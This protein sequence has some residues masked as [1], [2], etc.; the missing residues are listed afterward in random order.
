MGANAQTSVP[1]FTAGEVLTAAN[2][3]ISARTGVP[4][5]ATTGTRD[6]AFGG[7]GEKTLA[8][9]QMCYV[10]GTG[11]QSYN[12]TA[13]VTWGTS[14]TPAGVAKIT[15]QTFSAVSSVSV[16]N[17]FSSTYVNYRILARFTNSNSGPQGLFLRLRASSTDATT[18]Y[19]TLGF[20]GYQTGVATE[21]F[22]YNTD[23]T[24]YGNAT[25]LTTGMNFSVID[26]AGPFLAETT[27]MIAQ[28]A[29]TESGTSAVLWHSTW[30]NDNQTSYDGFT[31]SVAAGTITGTIYVYG[32]AV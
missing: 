29:L 24:R 20:R 10:E 22:G 1:T 27:Q 28:H 15:T 2:M 21:S 30:Y 5:F 19:D 13:W 26:M 12:G 16:N 8:E 17:C 7:T 14:L 31:I 3:N 18:N 25:N 32:Y 4:V 23:A 6:A 9:G 11:L